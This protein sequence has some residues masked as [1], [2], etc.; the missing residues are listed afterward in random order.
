MATRLNI[1]EGEA[2]PIAVDMTG[3]SAPYD[4]L[5]G[6]TITLSA[7]RTTQPIATMPLIAGVLDAAGAD[8]K[9]HGGFAMVP[10]T[11]I[12]G[13]YFVTIEVDK[14]GAPDHDRYWPQKQSVT[15]DVARVAKKP[16]P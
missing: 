3:L 10:L 2:A 8:G 9:I 15:L 16:A 11:W 13:S 1:D 7:E 12:T 14:I 4:D 5:T 6:A